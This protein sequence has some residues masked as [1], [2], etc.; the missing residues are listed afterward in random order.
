MC[1]LVVKKAGNKVNT[2]YMDEAQKMN[3]NG[4]GVAWHENGYVQVYKT[5]N[6]EQFKKVC[7]ALEDNTLV[8]HL[9]NTTKGGT[10]YANIH[11]F[12][13]PTG[14][15]FHN[16]TILSLGKDVT[17]SD[18]RVLAETISECNYE[19]IEDILPL[20]QGYVNDS[21][22]R[23]VFF[24]D[25][26]SIVIVNEHL[27][28]YEDGDWYSNSY[29]IPTKIY[30]PQIETNK[31]VFVYGTLKKGG[32]N[33]YKHLSR[34]EFLGEATTVSKFKMIGKDKSFPFLLTESQDGHIIKGEVYNVTPFQMKQ[35]D[36][37]EGIPHLYNKRVISVMINGEREFVTTYVK[38]KVTASDLTEELLSEW[39]G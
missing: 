1:W 18:S 3:K 8:I 5:F 34:A 10:S 28:S 37:L 13:T 24:E 36:I 20:V 23:L 6:Y 39:E 11:P 14:V 33:H 19:K 31:K 25:E 27:G 29:H 21:I 9:R 32:H 26:G 30:T 12:E 16:G 15:L 7:V 35:L 38:S 22:N 2:E 4:Y 17:K